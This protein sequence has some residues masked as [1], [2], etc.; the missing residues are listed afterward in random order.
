MARRQGFVS[1]CRLA[2]GNRG[3]FNMQALAC[4]RP[5]RPH[6]ASC[7]LSPARRYG[8]GGRGAALR[9][10]VPW[11]GPFRA[12]QV[13]LGTASPRM[14]GQG[15]RQREGLRVASF[16]PALVARPAQSQ[17][18]EAP[19]PFC[20]VLQ[21]ERTDFLVRTCRKDR[22]LGAVD[23]ELDPQGHSRPLLPLH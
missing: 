7:P 1:L 21:A 9:P 17:T 6:G 23:Q 15:S 12:G 4:P 14:P 5:P 22:G 20:E 10:T 3:S 2:A 13:P 11:A 16:H 8:L 18:S 19:W